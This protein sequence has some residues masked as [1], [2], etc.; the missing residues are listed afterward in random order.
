MPHSLNR[1]QGACP[2][3]GPMRGLSPMRRGESVE[4][5]DEHAV[6]RGAGGDPDRRSGLRASPEENLANPIVGSEYTVL[7]TRRTCP[8]D[9]SR[10]PR[11][12]CISKCGKSWGGSPTESATPSGPSAAMC[13]ACSSASARATRSRCM[14]KIVQTVRIRGPTDSAP[15]PAAAR[16]SRS[17]HCPD[18]PWSRSERLAT[19]RRAVAAD[20]SDWQEITLKGVCT[21]RWRLSG[22]VVVHRRPGVSRKAQVASWRLGR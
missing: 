8:A 6:I 11:S 12:S 13:P 19:L 22:H 5:R 20:V 10:P 17:R 2:N 9:P 15:R 4:T 3:A 14:A 16:S 7:T 21:G 18:G 1:R